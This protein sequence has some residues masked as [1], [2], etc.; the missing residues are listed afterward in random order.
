VTWGHFSLKSGHVSE[1]QRLAG[2]LTISGAR[3]SNLIAAFCADSMFGKSAQLH[4][5][6][7]DTETELGIFFTPSAT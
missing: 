2:L 3:I 7:N 4:G 1:P 6:F 5:I